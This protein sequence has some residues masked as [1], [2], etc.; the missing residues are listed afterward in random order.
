MCFQVKSAYCFSTLSGF[1]PQFRPQYIILKQC[2]DL[3][4]SLCEI[5]LAYDAHPFRL[6]DHVNISQFIANNR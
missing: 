6:S 3:L 5:L 2:N 1:P 4:C